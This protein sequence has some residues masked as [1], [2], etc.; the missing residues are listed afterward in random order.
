MTGARPDEAP[1]AG[2]GRIDTRCHPMF[3][4]PFASLWLAVLPPT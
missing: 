3:S 2:F 4:A 1:L